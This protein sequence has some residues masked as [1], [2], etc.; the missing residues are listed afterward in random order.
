MFSC[1]SQRESADNSASS[2]DVEKWRGGR[3]HA[4]PPAVPMTSSKEAKAPL[5]RVNLVQSVSVRLHS[6]AIVQVQ[7]SPIDPCETLYCVEH[8]PE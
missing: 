1:S 7:L 5:V 8:S 4:A 2:Q 6:C 3:K